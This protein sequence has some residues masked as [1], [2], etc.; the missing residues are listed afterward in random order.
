[1][2]YLTNEKN[3]LNEM[4]DELYKI[5]VIQNQKISELELLVVPE[6]FF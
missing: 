2:N 3:K 5:Q 6:V 4:I 1:M